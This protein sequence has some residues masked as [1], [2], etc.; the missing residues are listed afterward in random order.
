LADSKFP[1]PLE[2]LQ[3]AVR[4][5]RDHA[6]RFGVDPSKVGAFGAAEGGYLAALLGSWGEGTIETGARIGATVSLS[7]VMDLESLLESGRTDLVRELGGSGD[8]SSADC[9]AQARIESPITH[10][11][12]TDGAF[13]LANA[14][15]ESVPVD[16][17]TRMANRLNSFDLPNQ[18]FSPSGDLHGLQLVESS[19][20][21]EQI[22]AFFDQ[23][24]G[25]GPSSP[26]T[27]SG[28]SSKGATSAPIPG[29]GGTGAAEGSGSRVPS[30][31]LPAWV[32]FVLVVA[33]LLAV[34]SVVATATALRGAGHG[35][36]TDAASDPE[37]E[38]TTSGSTSDEGSDRFVRSE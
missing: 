13:F 31:G 16:Q 10:V 3:S 34:T 9:R 25:S 7:G 2:D 17:T 23:R 35:A 29:E 21:F 30:I 12:A 22:V 6:D 24:L 14:T 1:A 32:V 19:K 15:D 33:L 20:G 8:C 37:P 11:D 26:N 28:T 5:I 4:Y 27:G 18:V 38:G 36:P